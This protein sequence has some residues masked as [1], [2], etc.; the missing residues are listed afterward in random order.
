MATITAHW[1]DKHLSLFGSRL[2]Q[3]NT[4]F[5]KVLPRIVNQVGNRA[6]TQVIRALTKQTG[7]QRKTIVKAIG[8]PGVARPGK[9]SY[10]MVTRGGNI[11]LKYLSPKETRKGVSAKPFGQRKVFAGSF[12]KGGKFPNRQDVPKFYGHV[13]H[14]LNKSGSRITYTRSDV[15]IPVEMTKG[16]TKAAFE[17]MAAPLL[18]ERVDAAIKKLLP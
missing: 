7:L 10:D 4:R 13:F 1:A 9:L 3:L 12:M 5:P 17:R 14:R 8:D 2:D 16:S 15:F 18:Q 6:K 11:R